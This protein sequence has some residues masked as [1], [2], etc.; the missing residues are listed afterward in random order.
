MDPIILLL[1]QPLASRNFESQ[2]KTLIEASEANIAQIES[3]IRDLVRLRD[4]ECGVI[5]RLR[6]AIAPIHK[7]PTELLVE[8]FRLATEHA[9]FKSGINKTYALSQLWTGSYWTLLKAILTD[10]YVAGAKS[11]QAGKIG[12]FASPYAPLHFWARVEYWGID[13]CPDQRSPSVGAGDL[14]ARF[15]GRAVSHNPQCP[16][17]PS[18]LDVR[19]SRK[20]KPSDGRNLLNRPSSPPPYPCFSTNRSPFNAMVPAH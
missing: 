7:L 8:V 18:I 15:T 9:S 14:G 5:A 17:S 3:Q 11:C 19:K 6:L 2:A 16:E 10:S 13:G 1:G 4:R 12:T 20:A